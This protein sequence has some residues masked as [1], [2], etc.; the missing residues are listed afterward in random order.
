MVMFIYL[1]NQANLMIDTS[2]KKVTN[3]SPF[4]FPSILFIGYGNNRTKHRTH[5]ANFV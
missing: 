2:N 5:T 3:Q 1:K 4:F